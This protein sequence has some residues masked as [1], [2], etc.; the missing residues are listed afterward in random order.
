MI[1]ICIPCRDEDRTIGVL[2]WKIREVM[3]DLG[4][5]FQV[6][7]LDDGSRDGTRALLEKY[8]R[9]LPLKVLT[10]RRPIGYGR[11]LE[12]LLRAAAGG[13]RYPRR[14]AIVTMQADFTEH[15][16]HLRALVRTFEG[17]ADIVACE[18]GP[19]SGKVPLAV[20]FA[21]WLGAR[22]QRPHGIRAA[23][24][25]GWIARGFVHGLPGVRARRREA[26]DDPVVDPLPAF[27]AYRAVVVRKALRTAG[28]RPLVTTDGWSA[29]AELMRALTPF[30]RRV[31]LVPLGLRYDIRW[32]RT[33][34]RVLPAVRQILR[35]GPGRLSRLAAPAI[36]L[37]LFAVTPFTVGA[38]IRGDLLLDSPITIPRG[39]AEVPFGPGEE[40]RYKVKYGAF[41]VGEARMSVAGIDTLRGHPVYATALHIKASPLWYDIDHRLSS[42]I[43]T[44]TLVSRRFVN[45]QRARER[46]REYEIF[47]EERRVQRIDHDTTWA[48]PTSEPLDDIAFVY[49]A[50][51][52]PLEV[53]QTY[54]YNR[55]FKEERNPIILKVLRKDKRE[56]G[57]GVFNTVVVQ[58]LIPG[59][60]FFSE[61]GDAEIHLSDDERRLLVYMKVD[62]PVLPL[63][64]TM[65]LEEIRPGVP[66][67]TGVGVG[68]EK[69]GG[70]G[71]TASAAAKPS[72]LWM[73]GTPD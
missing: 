47:P 68:E 20:R 41:G 43:D 63:K 22:G 73:R 6:F 54:E 44:E 56:V 40:L 30:A 65:H 61:G 21:R 71:S 33:R 64:I 19:A 11:A 53:G 57:A 66:L 15:P 26:A 3:L 13:T 50:R 27:R 72:R 8:G 24:H 69:A 1:H 59:S 60:S 38:Q 34:V 17:G 55:Y 5:D 28:T 51:T 29:N 32:R 62:G 2:L 14:D 70:A 10:E 46:Y 9:V 48:I 18:T 37:G 49:L 12:K 36:V 45:D 67:D 35:A 39:I 16:E 52:L 7:V 31:A 4:R 23:M 58:P 25:P 42:W